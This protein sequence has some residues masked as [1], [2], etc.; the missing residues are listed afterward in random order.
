M[1]AISIKM[2][3][4]K[5]TKG[6][7]LISLFLCMQFHLMG[8]F[9]SIGVPEIINIHRSEYG[10]DS[11]SWDVIED[12]QGNIYFGNNAGV[13]K[14]DG[15]DWEIFPVNNNSIVRSLAYGSDG[16]IYVGAYNEIGVLEKSDRE[17]LQYFSLN[18]F[19]PDQARNFDDVLKIYQT[20]FGV[21]FQSFEYLFIY[22]NDTIEIIKPNERFGNSF[23]T[24]NNYY[25]VEKG[26][27]LRVLKNGSLQSVSIDPVFSLDEIHS[28]ETFKSNDLLIGTLSNGL[29]ILQDDGLLRWDT[30]I[31]NK[32]IEDKLYC[33]SSI[34]KLYLFGTIKNGLY[35]VDQNGKIKQHLNRLNGLQNNTILSIFPDHQKNIWLGLDNG[36]DFLKSSLPISII[37]YNFNIATAYSTVIYNERLYVGTNQGLYS[38]KLANLRGYS[39]I[40]FDLVEGMDGQVWN[41]A[42]HEGQL[43]CGHN[44]GAYLIDGLKAKKIT[45][46]RGIWNFK[47]IPGRKNILISGTYDGLITFSKGEDGA[48]KF[49]DEVKGLDVSSKELIV[50]EDG[51]IW[52]SHGY[53]GLFHL[54]LNDNL[55]SV[56]SLIEYKG[57]HHLP[58]TLP[59]LIHETDE[60]FFLSTYDGLYKFDVEK[61]RFYKP[62]DLNQFFNDLRLIYLIHEDSRGNI[63]YSAD[64]G[65][66]LYRFLEDGTYT[67]ISTP[68][69]DLSNALI[70]PF[71]NIYIQDSENVYIGTQNGL[72]HY[73][74]SINK[75]Y[76]YNTYVYINGVR[77]SSKGKD[78]LWYSSGNNQVD[79]QQIKND[80]SI[81]YAF[82]NISFEFN[83]PDLE[84]AGQIEYSYRLD[85]FDEKWSEWSFANL[86]EYTN[87]REGNYLFEVKARNTYN[88]ISTPDAFQFIIE[89]PFYRSKNAILIYL[90]LGA[91]IISIS[92]YSYFRRIEKVRSQE[93]TKHL[94]AFREK[95]EM[96]QEQKFAAEK[97]VVQLR[98][99]RLQVEMKHKNKELATSTFHIIQKNKFLNTLKQELSKLS[100]SAKS[101]FVEKELKKI[102][103]KIDRDIQNEKNWEVFDRY[104]DEVHQEFL[105]RLKELHPGLTPKELR[106]SAYL[107]INI[108]TKEIA[109]LMNISVRGVEISR[110]RLRKK[111]NLDRNANLT[112]YIMQV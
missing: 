78:S 72:V 104:F 66:G 100:F 52:M 107:R 8:Q 11:Q 108:S 54:Q 64:Q 88:N 10:G 46:L 31:S 105:G 47:E 102:G 82:N 37:N 26:I 59:Y 91:G 81:P 28:I 17:G 69:L 58:D 103:R 75:N 27:G 55:D 83:S 7:Y 42:I 34:N 65:M 109:P 62:E 89:P 40:K 77:I 63:W 48:W 111:L 23:Y 15:E 71:D 86:K 13:M 43:L 14:F 101:E 4:L 106:I 50:K 44:N 3:L 18:R 16:R 96:L 56:V 84:N 30:E 90:I 93:K 24:N 97:E 85:N 61:E 36:I 73:N 45:D 6:I 112:E 39:D 95:E 80:F 12:H 110:Y 32:L 33:G 94:S 98:N 49:R 29:Y 25:V 87:L 57:S 1:F 76:F 38:K 60:D 41:L 35:I 68:F 21:I 2:I 92:I 9:K 5:E 51:T 67:K 79:E 70:S 74:P 19:I 99:E 20:R 53:L 22:N